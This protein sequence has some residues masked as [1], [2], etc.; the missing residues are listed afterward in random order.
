[1]SKQLQKHL[2]GGGGGGGGAR[3]RQQLTPEELSDVDTIFM[4][5]VDNFNFQII[6]EI[7]PVRSLDGIRITEMWQPTRSYQVSELASRYPNTFLVEKRGQATYT[8][9]KRGLLPPGFRAY[10]TI[11]NK[12]LFILYES[13]FV[14]GFDLIGVSSSYPSIMGYLEQ[15]YFARISHI[16]R[17]L[18]DLKMGAEDS[19]AYQQRI[20]RYITK[21]NQEDQVYLLKEIKKLLQ[22]TAPN[23]VEQEPVLAYRV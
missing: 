20:R 11:D 12:F 9:F 19:V 6:P 2:Q 4:K 14:Y 21:K 15:G 1:M 10:M 23:D 5:L 17:S 8:S 7:I 18:L 22:R 13:I 16:L 3:Q